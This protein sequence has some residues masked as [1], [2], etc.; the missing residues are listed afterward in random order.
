MP[1]IGGRT[2]E[3]PAVGGETLREGRRQDFDLRALRGPGSRWSERSKRYQGAE[4]LA[5]RRGE[6]DRGGGGADR[7]TLGARQAGRFPQQQR[8]RKAPARFPELPPEIALDILGPQDPRDRLRA[9]SSRGLTGRRALR[10][11]LE[12]LGHD[13]IEV[14]ATGTGRLAKL[15]FHGSQDRRAIVPGQRVGPAGEH[16]GERRQGARALPGDDEP[17]LAERTQ[18]LVCQRPLAALHRGDERDRDA[19]RGDRAERFREQQSPAVARR[20]GRLGRDPE[21]AQ[22]R[23]APA[24]QT[25]CRRCPSFSRLVRR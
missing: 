17:G 18:R 25:S 21:Y 5:I 11:G 22:R 16:R 23:G 13:R 2:G 3:A 10:E 9:G 12:L 24:G 4:A 15:L 1:S 6:R 19:R 7:R 20:P 14:D 8:A